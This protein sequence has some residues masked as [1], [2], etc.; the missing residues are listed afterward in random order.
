VKIGLI[1][2]VLF[3]FIL[4]SGI[5]NAS[6]VGVIAIISPT[7]TLI[8]EKDSSYTIEI[9]IKN[10]G[11]NTIDTI[12][13]LFQIGNASVTD[14]LMI[15]LFPDS[16]VNF[17]FANQILLTDTSSFIGQATTLLSTDTNQFNDAYLVYY[18]IPST[19]P[20]IKEEKI[21]ELNIFP[22]PASNILHVSISNFHDGE[23]VLLEIYN[24]IG[25]LAVRKSIQ[26]NR[27][28]NISSVELSDFKKGWYIIRLSS[29]KRK[30]LKKF[31]IL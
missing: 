6:D 21:I 18:N 24:L 23:E 27:G 15:P 13:L 17:T 10:Y 19:A 16:Q 20:I 22:N 1:V 12:P 5:L 7:E 28:L 26:T 4:Q 31:L 3:S 30:I 8:L 14:T 29:D 25:V 2:T 9:T 11:N